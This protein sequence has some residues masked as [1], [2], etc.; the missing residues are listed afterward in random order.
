MPRVA[1]LLLLVLIS[2]AQMVVQANLALHKPATQ[3]GIYDGGLAS[4][5]VDGDRNINYF[6]DSCT[7]SD[8]LP[9]AWWLVDLEGIYAIKS[10]TITNR[11]GCCSNRL[12]NFTVEISM[13]DP[14][15]LNGF[16]M[17]TNSPVCF[18]QIDP[19]PSGESS[20]L[21]HE[22]IAGR[23]VRVLKETTTS[24][25]LTLCEV[26]I[27][28]STLGRF[29]NQLSTGYHFPN[30]QPLYGK[31]FSL[32]CARLCTQ[33]KGPQCRKIHI[34]LPTATCQLLTDEMA[35]LN[36]TSNFEWIIYIYY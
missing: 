16:P 36:K 28:G 7:Q 30:A 22:Q 13:Q 20:F 2:A 21:C 9:L 14:N 10:I 33:H 11:G 18:T 32:N 5:A 23:Y 17:K 24:T 29:V 27:Y 1:C 34:H 8:F 3:S 26:E 4:R 35:T 6:G 31:L 25:P 12:R 19:L 15:T